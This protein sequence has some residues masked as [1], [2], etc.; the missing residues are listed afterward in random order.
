MG[1]GAN[2]SHQNLMQV[3]ELFRARNSTKYLL[4]PSRYLA[5]DPCKCNYLYTYKHIY[6]VWW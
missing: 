6:F 5:I 2:K 1:A 4:W 3:G